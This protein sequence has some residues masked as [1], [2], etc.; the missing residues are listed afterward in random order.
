MSER[1][2]YVGPDASRNLAFPGGFIE[3]PRMRW[4]DPEK[5]LEAAH[6]GL[7]HLPIVLA[8]LGD[9]FE[10]EGPKKAA[11]TR[12]RNAADQA[13]DRAPAATEGDEPTDPALPDEEQS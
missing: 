12:A 7:H 3:F 10:R 1:Y 5:E 6:I 8:G 4:V 9:D 2:R 13:D 11:R